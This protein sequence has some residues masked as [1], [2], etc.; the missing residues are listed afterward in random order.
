AVRVSRFAYN[1]ALAEWKRQYQAGEKPSEGALRRQ[2]NFIK[3][4]QFPWM[5]LVPKSVPQQAVKNCGAAFQRFFKKQGRYPKFKKKGVRDSARLDNGPGTFE[6]DGQRIRL[7]V[8]GWVKLR[9]ELRFSGKAFSATVRR[10]ADRW[11]VSVPVEIDLPEPVRESQAA[12]GIDLGVSTAATL[13]SGEK[14]PGPKALHAHLERLQRLSRGHSRKKKGSHNRRKSAMRLARLHARISN[15][16]QDWLHQTTTRLV[17][18]FQLMGIEDLNVRGMMANEKLARN[19]GDIGFHEFRRQL[20][21]KAMLYGADLVTASRWFPS[22]KICSACGLLAE[23]LPLSIREWTCECGAFHDRDINAARNL[24][25]YAL[26]RASCA[27]INACGEEGSDAGLT[28]SVKP[29][30]LKQESAMSY[31]GMD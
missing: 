8:I 19:I 1:W 22:S 14:L 3:R 7:P 30:S 16:R 23:G 27:R 2:L 4:Q 31:L 29:A 25:R 28:A 21:Y 15:V 5:G 9:E 26:D 18:E 10:V 17:R 13:S 11:F 20:E 12:V 24:R 6:F